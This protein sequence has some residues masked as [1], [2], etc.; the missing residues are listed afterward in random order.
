[1]LAIG[2]W[3]A[4]LP[5]A[6]KTVAS[7]PDYVLPIAF[8]GVLLCCLWRGPLRWLG[9][10]LAM[11]VMVWPRAPTPD[12]WIGDGGTQAAFVLDSKAVVTRPGVRQFAVDV[13]T[14]RRGVE[15]VERPTEGWTCTRFS[16][17]PVIPEAGPVAVWW[18]KKAPSS[19]QLGSLCTAAEVVSVRASVSELPAACADR[20]VLDGTDYVRGGAIELWRDPASASG[21]RGVWTADVRGD[22]PWSRFGDA[23]AADAD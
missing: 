4:G 18:G 23:D 2:A 8:L 17:A 12:L 11:A 3:T 20:L 1:M 15:P 16:C 7:A 22:R 10:P 19:D 13:W 6:V 5:G 21:W 14:R 9:L